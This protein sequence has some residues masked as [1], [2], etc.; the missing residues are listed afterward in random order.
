MNQIRAMEKTVS[1]A[2]DNRRLLPGEEGDGVSY[3]HLANMYLRAASAHASGE[4]SPAKLGRWLGYM[5]GVLVA[6]GVLTLDEAKEIN[7]EFAG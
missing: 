5:Q 1:I 4:M 6:K 3:E 7:K 2:Y